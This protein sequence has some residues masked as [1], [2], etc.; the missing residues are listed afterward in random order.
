LDSEST[1]SR[2]EDGFRVKPGMT[3]NILDGFI[4]IFWSIK[5]FSTAPR[6]QRYD[7][8]E[9]ISF[10]E[11]KKYDPDFEIRVVDLYLRL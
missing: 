9:G 8:R 5:P 7:V 11:N 4:M 1:S 3:L 10:V 2:L 6:D